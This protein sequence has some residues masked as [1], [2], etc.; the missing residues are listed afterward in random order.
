MDT[1]STLPGVDLAKIGVEELKKKWGWFLAL[2]VLLIVV[3]TIALGSAFLMTVFSMVLLGWLMVFGGIL[4]AVHAFACKKWSGFFIDL[5][6]GLL[7]VVVGFMILANPE[8]SA[9][10]LTL[11]IAVFLIFGGIF[12]VVLS[13]GVQYQNWGWLLL[14]GVISVV[15]GVLIWRQWPS[16]GLW[17][18]GMFVGIDMIFNGWTL[19]MLSLAAKNMPTDEA[20]GA[21]GAT[22]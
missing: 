15:L 8:A 5:L 3:G 18:I 7:Y 2:G 19:V 1:P 9:E 13:I 4:E 10:V 6:T 11:L 22:A 14:H 21:A 16:S 17:V 12:R 20:P